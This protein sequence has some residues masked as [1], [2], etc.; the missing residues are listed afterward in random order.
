MAFAALGNGSGNSDRNSATSITFTYAESLS[1]GNIIILAIALDNIGTTTDGDKGDIVSVTDSTGGN[2][3][4]KAVEFSNVQGGAA[5]GATIGIYYSVLTAAITG[6]STTYTVNFNGSVAAKA[7][8]YRGFSIASG[9]TVSLT[10]AQTL[11]NDG[12]DAGSITISGLASQEYLFIRACA[13]E[14]NTATGTVSTNFTKLALAVPLGTASGGATANMWVFAEYRI[15]TATSETTNP[16]T[17]AVDNASAMIGFYETVPAAFI[18]RMMLM[19]V[20]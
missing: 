5:A 13:I 20:G 12:A 16:V 17:A 7:I 3:Y 19:G 14:N 1:V 6:S 10:A 15:V 11:A 2:T 18:P 9:N 8:V 4:L